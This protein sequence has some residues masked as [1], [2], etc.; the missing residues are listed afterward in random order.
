MNK[1]RVFI[2]YEEQKFNELRRW[3]L[4]LFE[5]TSILKVL[6]WK[7]FVKPNDE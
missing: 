1:E 6:W 2:G 3:A 5:S 4:N 7:K